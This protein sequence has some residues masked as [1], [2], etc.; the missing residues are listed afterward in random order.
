MI[1][2]RKRYI[3]EFKD[4]PSVRAKMAELPVEK[5]IKDFSEVEFVLEKDAAVAEAK[6]CLSCRRCLGCKLCLAACE[7]KAIAF[8]QQEEEIELTVDSIVI[9]PGVEKVPAKIKK[10]LGY[11]TFLNVVNGVEFESILR[12][13]GPYGGLILRP[14]D[15]EIPKAIAFTAEGK[16]ALTYTVKEM[17]AAQKKSPATRLTLFTREDPGKVEGIT[18]QQRKGDVIAVKVTGGNHNLL[19][20]WKENGKMKEEEYE[21]VVVQTPLTLS[22]ETIQVMNQLDILRPSPFWEHLDTS[23]VATGKENIFFTGG[24]GK[25]S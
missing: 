1:E 16:D 18:F 3:P 21:M 22:P 20:Q 12:D 23:L 7:P 14:S 17:L 9:A 15:G 4:I 2:E 5:R 19:V 25:K 6:R 10:D 24:I 11:G 8:D 13:D